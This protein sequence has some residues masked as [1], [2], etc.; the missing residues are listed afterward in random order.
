M[1]I[2]NSYNKISNP[3]IKVEDL[4]NKS[5]VVFEAFIITFSHRIINALLE[6]KIIEMISENEIKSISCAYPVY[7]FIGTNIGI[8]KTTVGAP[9]TS[10]LIEEVAYVYSCNKAVIFGTCGSLDKNITANSLIVP[11][12]AYRDEGVSYHYMEVSDYIEIAN[13]KFLI[14]FFNK[15]NIKYVQG[16]TWTTDAF[17]RETEEEIKLRKSEG[18]IAVEMELAACQAVANY[19][20]IEL[21]SFFYTAD[22][23]DFTSWD[24]GQ[25]DSLL[26]KDKRLQIL[27]IALSIAKEITTN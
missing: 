23:L 27:N 24:K 8:V 17:Y 18:C 25:R 10:A 19:K 21:Y 2:V 5:E 16:K 1:S 13:A 7:R 4:Y 12:F 14:N 3:K 9:I 26:T 22:N 11:T 20:R 15:L 6:D